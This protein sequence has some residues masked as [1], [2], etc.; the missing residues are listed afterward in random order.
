MTRTRWSGLLLLALM[1]GFPASPATAQ[2]TVNP[3]VLDALPAPRP[4]SPAR[5]PAR[6]APPRPA[7][8]HNPPVPATQPVV[9]LAPPAAPP[10]NAPAP[11]IVPPAVV[12]PL[13]RI[14]PPPPVPVS[15]DAPGTAS[16]LPAGGVRITFGPDRQDLNPATAQAIRT[17]GDSVKGNDTAALNVM[18]YAAGAPDDLST[19]RRLSLARALAARAVLI[20]EGLPSTRIYVRALGASAGDGPADRVDVVPASASTPPTTPSSPAAK[21]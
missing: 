1:A 5:T 3:G 20:A 21:P 13:A 19:P 17:F 16:P 15:P 12:V 2:V 11:P 10:P 7:G 6:P 8:P 14:A 4:A 18:A 9:R